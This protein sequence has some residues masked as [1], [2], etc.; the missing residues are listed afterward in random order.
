MASEGKAEGRED[1]RY[2]EGMAYLQAGEWQEAIR[3]FQELVCEYPGS[4]D[5]L[6]ALDE[7]EFRANLDATTRVRAKRWIMPWRPIVV[8]TLILLA[9]AFLAVQGTRLISRQVGPV[10]AQ[11]Q[12]RR[13]LAQLEAEGNAFLEAGDLD[14]AEARYGELLA[15][16]PD[17][18]AASQGLE[19]IAEERKI[20]DL[21]QRAVA[22]QEAGDYEEAL[23]LFT[24]ILVRRARYGDVSLR[25]TVIRRQQELDRL[26]AEA[27]ADYREGRALDAVSK[28]EQIKAL[29]ASY[30]R[31]LIAGRLYAL[32][33]Q[34]GREPIEG[35]PPAPEGVPQAIEYFTQAL[36]LQPQNA[37]AAL[38]QRLARLYLEGQTKYHEGRWD[39]AIA[40]IG[41]VYDQR[42]DY[43]RGVVASML[44]DAYVRSGDQ[45]QH[46][47]DLYLAYEQYHK[48]A[49][50]PVDDTTLARG[51]M[52][53]IVPLLT[54]TATPTLTPTSTPTPTRTPTPTP[55]PIST[56]TP[57]L[58]PT[59]TPTPRPLL[60]FRNQI[61]FF[62]D[63]EEQPGLWVMDPR[64]SHR[65]Y[66]GSSRDYRQQYDA[67]LK[68][69]P[70]SPDGR[71][72]AFVRLSESEKPTAQIFIA[73]PDEQYGHIEEQLTRF[74]GICYD[75][76]WSPDGSRIA[77]VS[78]E[79]ESDDIWV[80]YP[81]GTGADNLT[82]N[83]WEW[84]KH[85]SWS[86]DS[87]RIVFWSN[88]EGTKQI[89]VMDA[90]GRNVRN[91]SKTEWDEYDPLWIK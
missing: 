32:Y 80:I 14:A 30:Q 62:S 89:H 22:L 56:P 35:D 43:L 67:L 85:P 40:R 2:Q 61:V 25:I 7:A 79:N 55:T 66:L 8:R 87:K 4:L 13:R 12:E 29:N 39:Q 36:A 60:A 15:A 90:N 38:E 72:R 76:V 71:L 37:E 47:G 9:V 75:P 16:V 48:A 23:K 1:L 68:R 88:R 63:D 11:A 6:R 73:L 83:P 50:L 33:L 81:D 53:N 52:F 78:D 17:H 84:D 57:I 19:S 91:I 42:P 3:C 70:F 31:D 86:P 28:Y 27:E 54:P 26:F 18:E 64:G 49:D 45:H 41:A 5:I 77:F 24:E 10:L 51:R 58:T 59:P 65:Q 69:E 46:A 21:Y 20:D 34:L 82:R 44:Y 74:T